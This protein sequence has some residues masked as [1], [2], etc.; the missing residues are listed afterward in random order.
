M[1]D[2]MGSMMG[3][4]MGGAIMIWT[5]FAVLGLVVLTLL[6]IWL[7]QQVRRGADASGGRV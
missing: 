1:M 6:A 2:D 3:W 7:F 5:V 4:M